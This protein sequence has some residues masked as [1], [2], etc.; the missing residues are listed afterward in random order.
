MQGT[1]STFYDSISLCL[2]VS[3]ACFAFFSTL[4]VKRF[5]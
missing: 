2:R 4:Q 5:Y 1:R 3:V